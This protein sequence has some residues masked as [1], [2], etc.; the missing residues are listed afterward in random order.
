MI[1]YTCPGCGRTFQVNPQLAGKV[2]K[3]VCGERGRVKEDGSQS[4]IDLVDPL[5]PN[6]RSAVAEF[7]IAD[8]RPALPPLASTS[9]AA[10]TVRFLCENC[11]A[12][13]ELPR[14]RVGSW[15]N[16]PCGERMRVPHPSGAVRAFESVGSCMVALI[17]VVLCLVSV[18]LATYF[19]SPLIGFGLFLFLIIFFAIKAA[20]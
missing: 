5:P 11:Y 14:Q 17:T 18:V 1:A 4:A 3:C 20:R 9:Q 6:V 15:F 2:A 19:C 7:A 13:A 10:T 16:C 12:V 8:E